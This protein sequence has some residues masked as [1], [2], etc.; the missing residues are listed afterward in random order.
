MFKRTR[1]CDDSLDK[2]SKGKMRGDAEGKGFLRNTKHG[3]VGKEMLKGINMCL[4]VLSK[5]AHGNSRQRGK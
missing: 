5:H 4:S 3:K 1:S 2:E